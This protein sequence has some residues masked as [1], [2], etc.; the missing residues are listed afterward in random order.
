MDHYGPL[1]AAD[2]SSSWEKSELQKAMELSRIRRYIHP[3]PQIRFG[4]EIMDNEISFINRQE[5][6]AWL[7]KNNS[8]IREVWLVY[9]K[10][11]SGKPSVTYL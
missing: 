4:L 8:S 9:Y 10:K 2:T 7:E 11:D 6:R 1:A 3:G 5:W